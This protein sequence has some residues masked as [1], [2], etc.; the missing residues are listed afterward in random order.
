MR[1]IRYNPDDYMETGDGEDIDT[2]M[3]IHEELLTTDFDDVN[4]EGTLDGDNDEFEEKRYG[5]D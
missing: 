1:D 4:F 5:L 3:E 2:S